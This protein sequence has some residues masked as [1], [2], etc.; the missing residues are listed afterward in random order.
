MSQVESKEILKNIFSVCSDGIACI[1]STGNFLFV[2]DSFSQ[3]LGYTLNEIKNKN[4]SQLI[5]GEN[6][7]NKFFLS[8]DSGNSSFENKFIKKSGEINN[9][10]LKFWKQ[11]NGLDE[12]TVWIIIKSKIESKKNDLPSNVDNNKTYLSKITFSLQEQLKTISNCLGNLR[13]DLGGEI[14]DVDD[15]I[16]FA[17]EASTRAKLIL[18]EL[19]E[20]SGASPGND[21]GIMYKDHVDISKQMN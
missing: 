15:Y 18:N 2:N 14:G 20:C 3:L 9:F 10:K 4:I 5:S 12:V 13:Q 19:S 21:F 8:N 11:Q 16:S 6:N 17:F 7:F 1:N